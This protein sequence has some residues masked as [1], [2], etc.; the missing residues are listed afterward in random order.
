[1]GVG[2]GKSKQ[3]KHRHKE[4]ITI[5]QDVNQHIIVRA[6]IED[7]RTDHVI[8][9]SP[10]GRGGSVPWSL[11]IKSYFSPVIDRGP[12]LTLVATWKRLIDIVLT[13]QGQGVV[14]GMQVIDQTLRRHSKIRQRIYPFPSQFS[15]LH[16]THP[17]VRACRNCHSRLD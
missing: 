8:I 14:C 17:H 9:K 13:R 4:P 11:I 2:L 7:A 6:R 1:M 12:C 10:E 15:S 5:I 16:D 3:H